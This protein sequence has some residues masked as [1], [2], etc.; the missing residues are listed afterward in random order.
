MVVGFEIGVQNSI[1]YRM[2]K[3]NRDAE[4]FKR[5]GRISSANKLA[6]GILFVPFVWH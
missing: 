5:K 4:N 2:P 6:F 3:M 1:V